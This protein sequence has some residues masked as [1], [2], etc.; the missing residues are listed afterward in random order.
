MR[1]LPD[2]VEAVGMGSGEVDY[3]AF[4]RGLA[5]GGYRG[6]LVYE[7]CSPLEGGPSEANL[8]AKALRF[9]EYMK[10]HGFGVTDDI[11]TTGGS[12]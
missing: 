8:D 2:L 4:F 5:E 11:G 12:A 7:M 1:E 6:P 9:I 3:P 10:S